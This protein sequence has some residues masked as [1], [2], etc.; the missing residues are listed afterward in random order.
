MPL[1]T[2]D[3]TGLCALL[4][5]IDTLRG[6][7]GCPWDR[8]QTL[9]SFRSYLQEEV[10][11]LADAVDQPAAPGADP[12]AEELGDALFNLLMMVRIG[13]EA[14]RFDLNSVAQGITDKMVQRHPHLFGPSPGGG[15]KRGDWARARAD[16]ARGRGLLDGIPTAAPALVVAAAQGGKARTVGFDWEGPAGVLDKLDEELAELKEAVSSG[17]PAA[18]RHELGDLLMAAASLGRHLGVD[19]EGALRAGN[20]RF[21]ER[22]RTMELEAEAEGRALHDMDAAALDAAWTRAKVGPAQ[23]AEG[24]GT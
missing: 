13:T 18:C 23:R 11:E 4:D 14:G 17:D 19:A 8:A 1:P 16:R 10:Y 21:A 22:F 9:Q 15:P 5:L 2:R 24:G 3:L 20:A 12:V 6:P 7:E